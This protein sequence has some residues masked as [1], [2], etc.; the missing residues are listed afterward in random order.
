MDPLVALCALRRGQS[1]PRITHKIPAEQ[2]PL[3][4]NRSEFLRI[5]EFTTADLGAG[6]VHRAAD[7][8][9]LMFFIHKSLDRTPPRAR[10]TT[11]R[12]KTV[13]PQLAR[14]NSTLQTQDDVVNEV[15]LGVVQQERRRV[16]PQGVPL[17]GA[18]LG[19]A[20]AQGS[21]RDNRHT[22][23]V[24]TARRAKDE[25][26][27]HGELLVVP[28]TQF[29]PHVLHAAESPKVRLSQ[30]QRHQAFHSSKALWF[31]GLTIHQPV[32]VHLANNSLSPGM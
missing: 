31:V 14:D 16:R 20:G 21:P 30:S 6:G 27:H 25:L 10:T 4:V 22:G 28:P 17:K 1:T 13:H 19:S 12:E 32:D 11:R 29:L 8:W 2:L 26:H 18:R 7:A 5:L 23:I 24:A 9:H 3:G 15:T